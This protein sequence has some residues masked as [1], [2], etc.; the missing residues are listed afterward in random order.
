MHFTNNAKEM[1]EFI[2]PSRIIKELDGPEDWR[3]KY[4]EPV[5]GE[6]DK[7]NDTAERD[8]LLEARESLVSEFEEATLQWVNAD[9]K[10]DKP[11]LK[12][13]RDD[14]ARKLKEDYWRLDPYVRARSFY[15][16]TGVIQPG[17]KIDF[18]PK[19]PPG[20]PSA[21]ETV[22]VADTSADDVD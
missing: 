2:E 12:T 6:N 18:Y 15:D 16:R 4:I 9:E 20:P 1:E 19:T 11:A 14:L 8:R 3:Y 10:V 22:P 5:D 7:M 17:G 21:K 13:K